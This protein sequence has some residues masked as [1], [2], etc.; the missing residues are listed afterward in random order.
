MNWTDHI[1]LLH[2]AINLIDEPGYP[3]ICEKEMTL[4]DALCVSE[5]IIGELWEGQ[6]TTVGKQ[7]V[8]WGF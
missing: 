4:T 1:E 2:E 6:E 3:G 8:P 7:G 5:Q